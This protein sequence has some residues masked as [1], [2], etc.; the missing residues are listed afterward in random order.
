MNDFDLKARSWDSNPMHVARSEAFAQHIR[1]MIPLN[2]NMTALDFG[3]GTG[4]TSMF[5]S[6]SLKQITMM[7]SSSGM[8]NVINEKMVALTAS[9]LKAVQFDLEHDDYR[10]EQFDLV[11]MQMVLHH[12]SGTEQI[13]MKFSNLLRP[14]GYLAIADTYTEDGSFHGEGFKGHNGFDP[15]ELGKTLARNKFEEI[16]HKKFFTIEKLI[17]GENKKFDLFILTAKRTINQ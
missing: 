11:F 15:D 2:R 8:I 4:S 12:I 7:D 6:D 10:D 16:R 5:L 3:A 14:G 17:N 1:N 9:N 13:I